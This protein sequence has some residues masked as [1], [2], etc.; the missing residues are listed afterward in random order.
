MRK[1]ALFVAILSLYSGAALAAKQNYASLR[2]GY[3]MADAEFMGDSLKGFGGSLAFGGY[4]KSLKWLYFRTEFEIA[5]QRLSQNN[6]TISPATLS[7]NFYIDFGTTE[8]I[9]RPYL[10]GGLV[11]GFVSAN[12][13]NASYDSNRS[14]GGIGYSAQVGAVGNIT[15]RWKW[16]GGLR[17]RAISV[18]D[19][20]LKTTDLFAGIRID[21]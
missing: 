5:Y 9:A 20:Q 14:S 4:Y 3:A 21:F 13:D 17:Y 18:L 16:E 10:G 15:E 1:V 7:P 8:W 19:F 11:I 6:I 2:L 12:N